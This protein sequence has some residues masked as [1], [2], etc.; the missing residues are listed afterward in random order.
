MSDLYEVWYD[1]G[2]GLLVEESAHH[3]EKAAIDRANELLNPPSQ[4]RRVEVRQNGRLIY[5]VA[6]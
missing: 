4:V 6:R 3:P 2:D 5:G 1:A